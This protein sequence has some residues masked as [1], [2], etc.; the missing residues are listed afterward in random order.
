LGRVDPNLDFSVVDWTGIEGNFESPK[1]SDGFG[2]DLDF[3]R[4]RRTSARR[5]LSD[6]AETK[7]HHCSPVRMGCPFK[8]AW[9]DGAVVEVARGV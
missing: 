4:G 1:S 9:D 5:K 3:A 8:I 6:I 2:M 7:V